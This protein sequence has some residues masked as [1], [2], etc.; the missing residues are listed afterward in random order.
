MSRSQVELIEVHTACEK[1]RLHLAKEPLHDL[2]K[3]I[4]EACLERLP[5]GQYSLDDLHTILHNHTHFPN[6]DELSLIFEEVFTS[7][8]TAMDKWF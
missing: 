5:T 7:V 8:H 3:Q 4:L 2:T 6:Y 1:I